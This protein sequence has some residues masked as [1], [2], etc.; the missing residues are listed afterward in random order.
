MSAGVVH[1]LLVDRLIKIGIVLAAL[2]VLAVGMVL[3]WK[4]AGRETEPPGR[5]GDRDDGRR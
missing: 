1:H 4:C 3:V 2:V 5:R